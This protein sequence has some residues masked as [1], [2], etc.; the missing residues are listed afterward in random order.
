MCLMV[1]HRSHAYTRI[2]LHINMR[3]QSGRHALGLG[4]AGKV[5]LV[6]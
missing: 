3:N 2:Q 5:I 4:Y 6:V 1:I